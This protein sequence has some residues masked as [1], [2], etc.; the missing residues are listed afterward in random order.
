MAKYETTF[1]LALEA[2]NHALY[3]LL[4]DGF[5]WKREDTITE[6]ENVKTFTTSK[7][8]ALTFIYMCDTD[9]MDWPIGVH[10]YPVI[11]VICNETSIATI[12]MDERPEV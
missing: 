4:D 9:R 2:D 5:T 11:E 10:T 1:H 6:T 3:Y 7:E 12:R 8:C